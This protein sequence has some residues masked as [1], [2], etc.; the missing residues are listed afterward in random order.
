MLVLQ[1]LVWV[2]DEEQA[3]VGR[4]VAAVEVVPG[5]I[6]QAVAVVEIGAVAGIGVVVGIEVVAGIEVAVGTEVVVAGTAAAVV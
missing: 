4:T 1:V 2:L 6:C 5:K 3:F